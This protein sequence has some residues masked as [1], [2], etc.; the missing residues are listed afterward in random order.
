MSMF[1]SSDQGLVLASGAT[2][3]TETRKSLPGLLPMLPGSSGFYVEFAERLSDNDV[4]H[5]PA[6]WLMPQE[7]NAVQA[8]HAAGDPPRYERWMEL[9]VDEGGF[10][11][12]GHHGNA[13][14]WWGIFPHYERQN[15]AIDPVSSPPMDRTQ[16]HIF[17][18]SYDPVRATVT[19]WVD[20]VSVGST[21]T[22]KM[23]A[24]VKEHHYYLIMSN[25]THGLN[26]PLQDVHPI[27][28]G[29]DRQPCA[30]SAVRSAHRDQSLVL[31][32]VLACPVGVRLSAWKWMFY[33]IKYCAK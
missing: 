7:H 24:I 13:I 31:G 10:N 30:Q 6:V 16:E 25:Q 1:S 12:T 26:R 21:S 22:A 28:H 32:N 4:D 3:T 27:F 29:M 17:G 8:D 18:L 23:H 15:G 5:W 2:L 19:W 33:L 11:K 20:G 9:D 14:S